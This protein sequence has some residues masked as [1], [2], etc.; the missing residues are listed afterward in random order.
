MR[1]V[2]FVSVLALACIAI[3]QAAAG[4]KAHAG[5][6]GTCPAGNDAIVNPTLTVNQGTGAV[7]T[8][9]IAPFCSN[10]EVNLASYDAPAAEFALPQTL[11]DYDAKPLNGSTRYSYNGGATYTLTTKVSPCFFQVDFVRG[12]VIVDL[13]TTNQYL[14]RKLQWLNGGTACPTDHSPP[15][16]ALT[17]T[18][19]G[20]P[21][22]L[23][24]TVQDPQ[25][26]L[27]SVN[28]TIKNGSVSPD[29][30]PFTTNSDGSISGSVDFSFGLVTPLVVTATKA[31]QALGSRV[32]LVVTNR[33]GLTTTCDPVWPGTAAHLS[34]V[35]ALAKLLSALTKLV[36]L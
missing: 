28:Y 12:P 36:T 3:P 30:G 35:A 5:A 8:F 25:S 7:A 4:T 34:P 23:Q 10:I 15:Q 18:I 22:R 11:I 20:P 1:R 26:G 29:A 27:Q 19:N 9:K 14:D 32:S 2:L 21:K 24:V 17:A 13:T 6:T 31:N 16:C 33:D